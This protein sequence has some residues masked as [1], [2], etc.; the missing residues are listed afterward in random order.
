MHCQLMCMMFLPEQP[1]G[2][3]R[4]VKSRNVQEG[5]CRDTQGPLQGPA[6]ALSHLP[7][8]WVTVQP[9]HGAITES[10]TLQNCTQA[11]SGVSSGGYFLKTQLQLLACK[12]LSSVEHF[13]ILH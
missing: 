11:P 6:V 5:L 9:P 7:E 3:I 1:T 12:Q 10:N 8:P 13:I 4:N 2:K